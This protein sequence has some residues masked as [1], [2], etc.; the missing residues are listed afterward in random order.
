MLINGQQAMEIAK[1]ADIQNK[2]HNQITKYETN[3]AEL[4]EKLKT[5]QREKDRLL[6]LLDFK[7]NQLQD[8]INSV[9]NLMSGRTPP[10]NRLG[11]TICA[12]KTTSLKKIKVTPSEVIDKS[13]GTNTNSLM[14]SKFSQNNLTTAQSILKSSRSQTNNQ[15]VK[16]LKSEETPLISLSS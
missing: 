9:S 12:G 1:M 10:D 14:N 4:S 3:L 16:Q 5:A 7:E 13:Q 11:F 15:M 2:M 6:E 8:A